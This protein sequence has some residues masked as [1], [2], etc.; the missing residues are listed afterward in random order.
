MNILNGIPAAA[1]PFFWPLLGIVLA[2]MG[3]A[4][5]ASLGNPGLRAAVKEHFV[6]IIIGSILIF[7]G[8]GMVG[9]FLADAGVPGAP[10]TTTT[11]TV[12]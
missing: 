9:K 6:W 8:V 7:G 3:F 11:A 1:Q 5:V 4:S 12:R 2:L 10:T